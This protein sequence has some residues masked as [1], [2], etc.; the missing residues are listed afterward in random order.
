MARLVV[1]K[2]GAGRLVEA[3][4]AVDNKEEKVKLSP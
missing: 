3:L 4:T 2:Q 1:S